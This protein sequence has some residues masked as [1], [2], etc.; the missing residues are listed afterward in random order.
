MRCSSVIHSSTAAT[1]LFLEGVPPLIVS[2]MLGYASATFTM[3]VY[4]HVQAA[5]REQ[6]RD[7]MQRLFGDVYGA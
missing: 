5:M 4:G 1:L 6:A 7:T 2:E 3:G